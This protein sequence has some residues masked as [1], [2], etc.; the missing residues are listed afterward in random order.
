M[1]VAI[2]ECDSQNYRSI[3]IERHHSERRSVKDNGRQNNDQFRPCAGIVPAK[4]TVTE[5]FRHKGQ[6]NFL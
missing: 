4:N 3:D 2:R 5:N 6:F 1:D